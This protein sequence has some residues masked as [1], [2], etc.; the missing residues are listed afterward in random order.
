MKQ[1]VILATALVAAIAAPL[2]AQ[3][4]RA[5]LVRRSREDPRRLGSPAVAGWQVGGLYGRHHRRREG[6]AQLATSGW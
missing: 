6:Q 4:K 3:T 1:P 5:V 2:S